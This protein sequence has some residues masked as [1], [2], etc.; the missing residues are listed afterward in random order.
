MSP[1]LAVVEHIK[2]LGTSAGQ[3]VWMLKLPQDPTLPAARVQLIDDPEEYHL[4]G[5]SAWGIARVQVDAYAPEASGLDPYTQAAQLADEI[6][7]DDAGSGLS[8]GIWEAAGSPSF[9]VTGCR[10]VDRRSSYDPDERRIV[11]VRQDFMV[12]YFKTP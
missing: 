4:R 9:R 12:H 5:G 1:E 3:R 6:N 8:G 7:G 10:R 11:G 2:D